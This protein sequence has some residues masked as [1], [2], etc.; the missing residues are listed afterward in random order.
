RSSMHGRRRLDRSRLVLPLRFTG[1]QIDGVQI[2]VERAD[3]DDA[4]NDGGRPVDAVLGRKPPQPFELVGQLSAAHARLFRIAAEDGPIVLG[5]VFRRQA[6][7]GQ[8][9]NDTE[10]RENAPNHG[11]SLPFRTPLTMT[12]TFNIAVARRAARLCELCQYAASY[13]C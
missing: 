1:G 8:N 13:N 6:Q 4:V 9:S 11:K 5:H 7:A 2:F 10:S 12:S 3:V